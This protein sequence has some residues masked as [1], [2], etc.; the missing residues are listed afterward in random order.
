MSNTTASTSLHRTGTSELNSGGTRRSYG[1]NL[2]GDRDQLARRSR[3][4][5]P[6]IATNSPGDRDQLAKKLREIRLKTASWLQREPLARRRRPRPTC[7]AIA[8]NSPGDRDQLAKKLREIRLKTA[9]WLQREPRLVANGIQVVYGSRDRW[10]VR[11]GFTR[12]CPCLAWTGR[13]TRFRTQDLGG[14]GAFCSIGAS[15]SFQAPK[16]PSTCAILS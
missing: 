3:P 10:P 11:A 7:P 6:A 1:A 2:P 14:F 9:S 16:P 15:A 5:R 4:T 13:G 8:T 12:S